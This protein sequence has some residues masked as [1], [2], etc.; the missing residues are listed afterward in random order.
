MANTPIT[1]AEYSVFTNLT[2]PLT[3]LFYDQ[4]MSGLASGDNLKALFNPNQTS[5][6]ASER[7]QG[8]GGFGDIPEYTGTI[9]YDSPDVLYQK[10]YQHVEFARG[11]A[12]TRQQV[13]DNEWGVINSLPTQLGMAFGRKV[14]KDM[15]SIWNNA[16][17]ASYLGG[18]SVALCSNSHPRSPN[19]AATVQD[20]LAT[21]AL[22][23]DA[24][25]AAEAAMLGFT[26]SKG[27]P[28]NI[29][30][31]TILVPLALKATA[32]V[33]AGSA[34]RSG[35]ANNDTNTNAG[36]NV[37]WSSYLTDSNNWFLI[38][39]MAARMWLRWFWRVQP[40]FALD[41]GS[42]FSLVA[43]YRGYM[44]YSYGWDHWAWI[45]GHSVT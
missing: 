27:Q 10:E 30:P 5:T 43:K 35:V 15:A 14:V 22:S 36:Y 32:Q 6:R 29:V 39:S 9:E 45:Y 21:T 25:V 1:N 34:L 2:T 42:D 37:I 13:D 18:D 23:H 38:D 3:A 17:S 41:P 26:D 28:L 11:F 7:N 4:V 33:I 20:N 31:D 16:F 12:V 44:R 19:D 40:E 8:M 24:V